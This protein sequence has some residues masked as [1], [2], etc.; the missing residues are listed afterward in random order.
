MELL[1]RFVSWLQQGGNVNLVLLAVTTVYVILTWR[2]LKATARQAAAVLQPVLSVFK[3]TKPEDPDGTYLTIEN[4]GNQPVVFLDVSV[5]VFRGGRR[6][7]FQQEVLWADEVLPTKQRRDLDYGYR[8]KLAEL[9]IQGWDCAYVISILAADLSRQVIA[10]YEF[11]P[12]V[13]YLSCKLGM[14]VRLRW[15]LFVRRWRWRYNRA[16]HLV[17]R[18]Q[19][20]GGRPPAA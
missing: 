17:S 13:G 14:P 4:Q 11:A 2:I 1:S 8:T 9:N 3:W 6:C 5:S 20:L 16:R 12:V 10:H 18:I 19:R 15:S 7:L